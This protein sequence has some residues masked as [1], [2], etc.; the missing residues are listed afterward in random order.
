MC[1]ICAGGAWWYGSREKAGL[2]PAAL[3]RGRACPKIGRTAARAPSDEIG[4]LTRA[5]GPAD[6]ADRSHTIV[7]DRRPQGTQIGPTVV[8]RKTTEYP[9]PRKGVKTGPQRR[10]AGT[11][12]VPEH[13]VSRKRAR[14]LAA[15]KPPLAAAA[16]NG[17][18]PPVPQR[19]TRRTTRA[20]PPRRPQPDADRTA[21]PSGSTARTGHSLRHPARH[22]RCGSPHPRNERPIRP[23][24]WC[25]RATRRHPARPLRCSSPRLNE[26]HTGPDLSDERT[27][28][29]AGPRPAGR[30]LPVDRRQVHQPHRMSGPFSPL[31]QPA[32]ERAAQQSRPTAQT[33]RSSRHPS[34]KA[35]PCPDLS[36]RSSPCT[37]VARSQAD[38]TAHPPRPIARTRRPS[39]RSGRAP[40]VQRP[41]HHP[42]R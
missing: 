10:P 30:Q 33:G 15:R 23:D 18:T 39:R 4:D 29:P 5:G 11:S 21:H 17:M 32:A 24:L 26:R 27:T 12:R 35:G 7:R 34:V 8:E 6:P 37:R 40:H 41:S 2:V 16:A 38:R 25:E 20:F 14:P 42:A 1:S 19:T 3:P 22:L 31:A 28:H 13:L 9:P 36:R